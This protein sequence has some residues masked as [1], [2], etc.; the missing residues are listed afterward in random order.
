MG[1][2]PQA[3]GGL[4][5]YPQESKRPQRKGT[6]HSKPLHQTKTTLL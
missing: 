3:R 2:T 6:N 1:K 5:T 4:T